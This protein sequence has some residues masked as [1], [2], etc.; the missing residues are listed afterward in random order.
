MDL[1]AFD[2]TIVPGKWNISDYLSSRHA[3]RTGTSSNKVFEI[4]VK[5]VVEVECCHVIKRRSAMTIE[6]ARK[7][8]ENCKLMSKLKKEQSR[9]DTLGMTR[10]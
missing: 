4:F 8:T 5:N 2:N 9:M 7:A 6:M 10:N 3:I 1:Q